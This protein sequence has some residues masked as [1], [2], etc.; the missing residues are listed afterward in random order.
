M[1]IQSPTVQTP[2]FVEVTRLLVVLITTAI[3][4]AIGRSDPAWFPDEWAPSTIVLVSSMLGAGGGYIGGGI[5]G[6]IVLHFLDEAERAVERAPRQ[7]LL[8][9]GLGVA[10]GV[11]V[12]MLASLAVLLTLPPLW[13]I[14]ITALI[15]WMT[16]TISYR[17]ARRHGKQLAR[18]HGHK[19]LPLT[20][21]WQELIEA[22]ACVMDSSAAMDGRLLP[23]VRTGFVS[24]QILVPSF[25]LDEIQ[26]IADASDSRRRRRGQR[27]LE[28]LNVLQSEHDVVVIEDA[29]PQVSTV[30]AKLVAVAARR[31]ARLLT[32]DYN[33]Q[34]VAELQGVQVLNINRLADA[35][36][37]N[38]EAGDVLS[39]RVEAQGSEEG[40]GVGYTADGQMVVVSGA[41]GHVGEVIETIVS[42]AH[43]TSKGRMLFAKPREAS[44]D[45]AGGAGLV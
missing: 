38:I 3:G 29:V 42:S 34:R 11:V 23:L 13:S 43:Q 2:A 24:L 1:I 31:S 40:Q 27:G 37:S 9:G 12:G 8:F 28:T 32:A 10:I 35:M 14:L 44:P 25:V 19:R 26:S 41:S 21:D 36:R 16:T 45:G 20:G 6:R 5:L 33:L 22:S 18:L 30:D 4:Y 39:V 7:E 15:V 17:L